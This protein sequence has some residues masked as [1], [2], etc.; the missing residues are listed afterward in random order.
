MKPVK[1]FNQFDSVDSEI[2]YAVAYY[3]LSKEDTRKKQL[4]K[5]DSASESDSIANQR[6]LIEEYVKKHPQ[7][8][9]VAEAVDDGYTGTNY[10]RPGFRAVLGLIDD[11]KVNCVIV[12]DLSR[13]GREYI[14]TGKYLEM[15]FPS[16]GVRFIAINDD[17]DS[18]HSKASDDILIPVK[19]I[20]NESY[21]RDQ[22]KKI[23]RQFKIQRAEGE[24]LGNFASYGYL[25]SPEDKHKLIID[26][27]ASEIIRLI[28]TLKVDGYSQQA[29]AD[30][31]N[32]HG[33]LPPSDY[34]K[35][36][37]LK[38]K[39]GFKTS[40]TCKWTAVTVR[41][42]L[43]NKIYIGTLIQGKRGTPNYKIKKMRLRN[44]CDW[45]VIEDNHP[46]IIDP[47]TFLAVQNLLKRDT[48]TSPT[49]ST[50]LPLSG[51]LYCA[52]CNRAMCRK[53]VT[54]GNK[55]F[56]YYVCSTNKQG[57][58]CTSHIFEQSKLEQTVLNAICSQ[59]N[60]IIKMENVLKDI[61]QKELSNY[62]LKR[63]DL[64]IAQ[65]HKDLD[66]YQEFRMRLYEVFSDNLMSKDEYNNMRTKYN[67]LI[68]ESTAAL[69]DLI[70]T[71]DEITRK[72]EYDNE[73]MREYS[74]FFGITK[75]TREVVFTLIDKIYVHD[76]KK[77][78]IEFNY[79]DEIKILSEMLNSSETKEVV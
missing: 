57:K 12:K 5:K 38:Y 42:I 74:K 22:S 56:Y 54:R 76:E 60:S 19:N 20:M 18:N 13:L 75:L 9:L 23:R 59:V 69:N 7:I 29:I 66:G 58:G 24:F 49:Q 32:Q 79:R 63:I 44:E 34:K 15:I 36:I 45:S 65:I 73:W 26:E 40:K 39:S 43:T 30:Y 53:T 77:I 25:K 35:S 50:V 8:K 6:K 27:I 72:A 70:A 71:R 37:G 4:N 2:Y 31:L 55:K 68:A 64:M 16:M 14:E 3:R 10:N 52:D 1:S 47:L 62:K 33:V 78:T 61:G 21:C 41:N 48:R 11:K 28:F 17:V 51:V 46:A 67:S